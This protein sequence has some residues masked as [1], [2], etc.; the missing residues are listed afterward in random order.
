MNNMKLPPDFTLEALTEETVPQALLLCNQYV[1]EGL[2]SA[3]FLKGIVGSPQHH[4]CLVYH[5][6]EAV[7]Y[8]YCLW[9]ECPEEQPELAVGAVKPLFETYRRLG[10]CRSIGIG[11]AFRGSGLSDALLRGFSRLL[12]SEGCELI[13]CPAWVRGEFVPARRLIEACGF[14]CFCRLH[15]PWESLTSLKCPHCHALHCVCD[16]VLYLLEKEENHEKL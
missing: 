7:G 1:G 9:I 10:V 11:N 2:Y 14:H 12:F 16:A 8:F 4:F 6:G 3:A 15:R 13:L 5:R